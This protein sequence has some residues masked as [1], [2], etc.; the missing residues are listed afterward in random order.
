[1]RLGVRAPQSE[2]RMAVMKGMKGTFA[3]LLALSCCGAAWGEARQRS[4]YD[5]I[6]T[7]FY[8]IKT[9][10]YQSMPRREGSIVFLG[11]SL[12]DY[13]PFHELFPGLPVLN[14]A[15]AGD[16][17][18]GVLTR[19]NEVISLKPAK[20][21]LLIGCNDIVF[22]LTADETAANIR[23]IVARFR[24]GSPNTRIYLETVL[25]VNHQFETNRPD[26]AIR[27]INVRLAKLAEELG[28]PLIDTYAHFAENGELPLRYTVDG[29]H[30]NGAGVLRRVEF[31][32][33]WIEM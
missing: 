6:N 23:Q 31:L 21:F 33:K 20:L 9:S 28:L 12:T 24:E 17:T 4:P 27:A 15:I 19:L 14:R 7:P 30:L 5:N 16:S 11:D 26:E 1:M 25:P 10:I 22:N 8:Q 2:G 32:S 29:I 18:V 3:L 13:I